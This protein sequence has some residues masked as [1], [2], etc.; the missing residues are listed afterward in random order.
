[1]G[2]FHGD[3]EKLKMDLEAFGPAIPVQA[4]VVDLSQYPDNVAEMKKLLVEKGNL[5]TYFSKTPS[6]DFYF[7]N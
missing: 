1:M 6:T 4:P 3:E 5:S 2:V 7:I